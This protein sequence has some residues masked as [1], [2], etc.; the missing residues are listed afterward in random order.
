[1]KTEITAIIPAHN[2]GEYI[3]QAMESV[4]NQT[5]SCQMI[6]VDDASTDQTFSAAEQYQK[7]FPEKVTVVR[8]E[9]NAGVAASRNRAVQQAHTEYI[10][11]LDAD[12]WWSAEKTEIQLKKLKETGADVCYSGRELMM[13]DGKPSGK[14]IAVPERVGY[15][16]LLKGNVVPCSSVIMRRTDALAYPMEHDELHEDY[17]MWLCMLRDGKKFVGV[18]EPFL[19]SR[20]GEGG[21]SRDKR[22]SAKM[23]FGVY[24][25]LEIP[26]W[27]AAYYFCCYAWRGVR[28]YANK[29]R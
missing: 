21:K 28:K 17:I 11:F 1:M 13:P 25:F 23:T 14:Q 3:G 27:K 8:N 10:A 18:N 26:A 6:I 9:K 7:R 20:L 12:D 24:R 22:K 16:E 19:K 2:A 5:L 4:L 15:E 29:K